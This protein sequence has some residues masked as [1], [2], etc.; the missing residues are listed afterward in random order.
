MH[1]MPPV[2]DYPV[3]WESGDPP[4]PSDKA[5]EANYHE[6]Q[7]VCALDP[8]PVVSSQTRMQGSNRTS[9]TCGA[10][11]P[12]DYIY[13]DSTPTRPQ[14]L[15]LP[16]QLDAS[17]VSR[18][19][20]RS[21]GCGN[22]VHS[23]AVFSPQTQMWRAAETGLHPM[24]SITPLETRYFSTETRRVLGLGQ[25]GCGCERTGIG[26][27]FCGNPLGAVFAPC[28]GHQVSQKGNNYYSIL[29]SAVS[30]SPSEHD[31]RIPARP[32]SPVEPEAPPPR[33][34]PLL[35]PSPP[36]VPIPYPV[37][38]GP[39]PRPPPPL[40]PLSA[41]PRPIPLSVRPP[42]PVPTGPP[43]RPPPP[44]RPLSVVSRD[45]EMNVPA[46]QRRPRHPTSPSPPPSRIFLFEAEITPTPSPEIPH[47]GLPV[48]Q[49]PFSAARSGSWESIEETVSVPFE[50][51]S[52]ASAEA[53]DEGELGA[54]DSPVI[55]ASDPEIQHLISLPQMLVQA[56]L[57]NRG[58]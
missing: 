42:V 41:L 4:R 36:R 3:G 22:P 37:P 45:D 44:L 30:P 5:I 49:N 18:K 27:R 11:D 39:P 43:P 51:M 6:I 20:K 14:I 54:G 8:W 10:E 33:L 53:R 29:P 1:E 12:L 50:S 16:L 40:R 24:M 2:M 34:S 25:K 32:L 17:A 55:Q 21:N 58:Y 15:A 46:R 13:D 26:C 47:V 38:R 7:R 35:T 48:Y 19:R 9:L 56:R 31:M 52:D 28:P 23:I 57:R